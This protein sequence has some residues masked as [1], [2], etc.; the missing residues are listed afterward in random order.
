MMLEPM[1]TPRQ[2]AAVIVR[3]L[4]ANGQSIS[5][6]QLPPN[7]QAALAHEMALMGMV[8]RDTRDRVIEEFCESLEQVGLT[9]PGGIDG[10]LE[11]LDGTISRDITDRLRRMAA[12][13][14]HADPWDR[15]AAMPVAQLCELALGEATEV[16]AV[17]FSKLPVPKAAEAFGMMPPERA[18]AIAYAM[19][20]TGGIEPPALRRIGV[21]LL[22]AAETLPAPVL[23]GGPIEKVGAILN[24]TTSG[25]RDEVLVGLDQDDADFA[26]EVR[27]AIF[28]WANIPKRIDPRDIPRIVREADQQALLRAIAG[29]K[30]A[31]RA[32][33][34]FILGALSSRMADAI[35]EDVE[36][37][38]RVSQNDTEDAMSEIVA[39]IRRMEDAGDLFL[40]AGEVDEPEG[41][42]VIKTSGAN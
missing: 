41:D 15:I 22:Q 34:E 16:A 8:D 11:M 42:I 28:T 4:L 25:T 9:F 31:N 37:L 38:G 1:L 21:A 20:M 33:A 29:A 30:D 39:G 23:D 26:N 7:A 24:F 35:R 27:K 18:R 12:M 19:S 13:T 32:S 17:M 14:G 36:T 6:E 2:K 5:L 40:I 10:T 3:L